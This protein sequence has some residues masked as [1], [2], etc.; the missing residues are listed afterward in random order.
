[1]IAAASFLCLVTR[2]HDGD[3]PLWCGNGMK[4]RVA[5]IQAPDFENAEPCRKPKPNYVCSDAQAE[6]SRRI[7]ERL[8][9]NKTM[10]CQPV[11]RSYQRVVARCTLPDGRSLSCAILAA[12]AAA[13]WDSYW[14][15][16]RMGECR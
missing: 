16:Y 4:V 11:G 14:H 9:L 2:V 3:G 1:M 6:R 10:S 8:A 13:R 12:G 15:R 5:G 7:V